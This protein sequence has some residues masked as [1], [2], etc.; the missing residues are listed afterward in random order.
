MIPPEQS[1]KC[2]LHV[3][4]QI[5]ISAAKNRLSVKVTYLQLVISCLMS[6]TGYIL[7]NSCKSQQPHSNQK[8]RRSGMAANIERNKVKMKECI[9]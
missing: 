5:T 3:I 2:K 9:W 6:A 7:Q 4:S 8:I 1:S